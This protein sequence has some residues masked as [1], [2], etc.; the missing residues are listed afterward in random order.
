MASQPQALL[1][2]TCKEVLESDNR[3]KIMVIR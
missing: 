3:R 1:Q 2:E